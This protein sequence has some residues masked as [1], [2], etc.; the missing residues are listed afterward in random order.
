M[1][2]QAPPS[3]QN[4]ILVDFRKFCDG[5]A[6]LR[7]FANGFSNGTIADYYKGT[8]IA[9]NERLKGFLGW[10]DK[11]SSALTAQLK[12]DVASGKFE[13]SPRSQQQAIFLVGLWLGV[14]Y[15]ESKYNNTAKPLFPTIVSLPISDLSNIDRIEYDSGSQKFRV[16]WNAM[17]FIEWA[18]NG[19]DDRFCFLGGVNVG[20]HECTHAL[21]ILEDTGGRPLSEMATY[22][23]TSEL[24]L[25]LKLA[26]RAQAV[27]LIFG[28]RDPWRISKELRAGRLSA[29]SDR[30]IL[31]NYVSYFIGPWAKTYLKQKGDKLDILSFSSEEHFEPNL[32]RYFE[33]KNHSAEKVALKRRNAT[34]NFFSSAG[35]KDEGLKGILR[36]VFEALEKNECKTPD[37]LLDFLKSALDRAFDSS[38]APDE[39]P[40]GF[41]LLEQKGKSTLSGSLAGIIPS[42]TRSK[43]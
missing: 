11:N 30:D 10:L 37:E 31:R 5:I 36:K 33:R 1:F 13:V 2:K 18:N 19:K 27:T 43:G 20:I 29:V 28:A 32:E 9:D 39:V 34:E 22:L 35:I 25:P 4:E 15:L 42:K 8:P 21:P 38:P 14:R 17:Q 41:V 7:D 16:G 6:G 24:A 26:G 23:A 12:N 3:P 40:A